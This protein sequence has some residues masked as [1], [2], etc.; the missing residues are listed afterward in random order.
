M[1]SP[2]P[3]AVSAW[4]PAFNLAAALGHRVS[5][6][7]P[8]GNCL[9]IGGWDRDTVFTSNAG[10]GNRWFEFVHPPDV[11]RLL[12]WYAGR[13]NGRPISWRGMAKWGGEPADCLM[14]GAKFW[15]GARASGAWI[16]L[17][18]YEPWPLLER[19]AK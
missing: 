17:T 5:V 12:A 4:R 1:L 13:T 3:F 14:V 9:A 7:R 16:Q 2:D 15:A 10:L 8:D 19:G 6:V 18:E 11:P